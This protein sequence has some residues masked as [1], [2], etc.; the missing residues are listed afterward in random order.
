MVALVTGS[1]PDRRSADTRPAGEGRLPGDASPRTLPGVR[2]AYLL[3]RFPRLSQTFVL[4]EL[5]ALERSGLDLVVLAR[6]GSDEPLQHARV[7]D[8]RAPVHLLAPG[9]APVRPDAVARRLRELEVDHV[10][11]HFATW[12]SATAA[13][14]APLAGVPFSFTAHATDLYRADVDVDAL[15]ARV[16]AARFVV[17]VTDD[18]R[19]WL[20]ARLDERGRSGRVLRLYNGMD[21]DRLPRSRTPRATRRLVAVGRLVEKKGFDDLLGALAL[22][23]AAGCPLELDLVGEGPLRP[24]LERRVAELGLGGAVRLL[25]AL[26]QEEVLDRVRAATALVLPAVVAADGD[27]DAL[28]TVVLEAMALG[29]PVVSTRVSG[30]PEMVEHDR[31]GL[32]VEQRDR[33]ALADAVRRL[34]G[35]P[36]LGERLADAA[37]ARVEERFSLAA[38]VAELR[39]LLTGEGR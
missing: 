13:A 8:L 5:L 12:A 32:L 28:P 16:A 25:G 29:T 22:L 30:I 23:E 36:A 34:V 35:E 21:L 38:N 14:A 19:R 24:Q 11:A 39:R 20:Q 1:S 33:A 7:S 15:A 9:D 27:R 37:R 26:P 17:T 4:D 3:K 18:N 31:S 10:H 2:V 6:R